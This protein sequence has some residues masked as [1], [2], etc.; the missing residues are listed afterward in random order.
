M[1][2]RPFSLNGK[3]RVWV[4]DGIACACVELQTAGGP[5]TLQ[6]CYPVA[7]AAV[8]VRRM[9]AARGAPTTMS[10]GFFSKLKRLAKRVSLARAIAPVLAAAKQIEKNPILARAVGLTQVIVPGLGSQNLAMKAALN[11][12]VQAKNGVTSAKNGLFRI[13]SQAAMGVPQAREA[14]K[15]ARLAAKSVAEKSPVDFL[16]G[17]PPSL[18]SLASINPADAAK[19]SLQT[20]LNTAAGV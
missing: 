3:I 7:R 9:L 12:V 5:L 1:I 17:A 10:G 20:L 19:S 8:M 2:E 4:K 11:L 15:L 6:A 13:A 14:L 18:L 16:R